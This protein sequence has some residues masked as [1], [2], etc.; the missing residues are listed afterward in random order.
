MIWLQYIRSYLYEE[1]KGK[2]PHDVFVKTFKKKVG[3]AKGGFINNLL[4]DI[5]LTFLSLTPTVVDP[6]ER[7]VKVQNA[8]KVEA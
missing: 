4:Q 5:R 7:K 6:E 1:T 3:N 2:N 8:E